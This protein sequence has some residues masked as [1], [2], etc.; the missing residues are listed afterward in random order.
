VLRLPGRYFGVKDIQDVAL[1]QRKV[2]GM[3]SPPRCH[4]GGFQDA[5][6]LG[7]KLIYP[8][9]LVEAA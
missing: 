4:F 9:E 7:G 5:G 2:E 3:N 8:L 6:V 1:N